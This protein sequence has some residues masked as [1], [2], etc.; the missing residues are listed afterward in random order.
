MG[1][2]IATNKRRKFKK[3]VLTHVK[4][5]RYAHLPPNYEQQGDNG[6][7]ANTNHK[8]CFLSLIQY[9]E[10]L[11][12]WSYC[13]FYT[14]FVYLSLNKQIKVTELRRAGFVLFVSYG[15]N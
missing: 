13:Q 5:I 3:S 8:L 9:L 2:A 11:G 6:E 7:K 10:Q 15:G 4:W 1:A 12:W 14:Y